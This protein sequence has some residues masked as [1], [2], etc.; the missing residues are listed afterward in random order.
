MILVTGNRGQLGYDIQRELGRRH[1]PC[2]GVDLADYDLTDETQ[3][4]AC[5]ARYQPDALVHCAA[6]TQVDRAEDEREACYAANVTAVS[7]LASACRR[8]DI[9]MMF[10]STDYVFPGDGE[11]PYE[12]NDPRDPVNYYGLTKKLAE[13]CVLS[14]LKKCFILRISWV[15]GENGRNF[16]KTML[17]LAEDHDRVSVVSDQIGSPTYTG[18]LARLAADMLQT[19]RYGVYHATNEGLCSWREFAQ[20]IFRLSGKDVQVAPVLTRDYPSRAKR[21]LNSRLSKASLDAAGFAR[22]PSWQ[23]A[24]ETYLGNLG[25]LKMQGALGVKE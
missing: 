1:V 22:L 25:Q 15:F 4:R 6:Y 9:P 12:V 2:A 10:F 5:F 20:E 3:V 11:T 17:R 24:L 18:D 13:D 14:Q 21:P 8:A 16:V 23:R 19:D 7:H